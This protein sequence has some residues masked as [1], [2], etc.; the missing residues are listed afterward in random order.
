MT[1]PTP[2]P[3]PTSGSEDVLIV[4]SD[5]RKQRLNVKVRKRMQRGYSPNSYFKVVN[6]KDF[7]D[8]ALFFEDL[9]LVMGA[10]L[11]RAYR[12]YKENKGDIGF[13][14]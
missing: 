12:K 10:P 9:E 8:L 11:E 13:P 7:N 2:T 14:F 4:Q 3:T 6:F 5:K 1:E